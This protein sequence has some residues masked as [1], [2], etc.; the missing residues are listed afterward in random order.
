[1]RENREGVCICSECYDVT[2]LH[3][4]VQ[5]SPL[6]FLISFLLEM[7]T[8]LSPLLSWTEIDALP[9]LED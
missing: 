7:S 6:N 2:L 9:P 8:G 3:K 1:M 5:E 4:T